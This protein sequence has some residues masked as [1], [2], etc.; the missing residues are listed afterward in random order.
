[1]FFS[2]RSIKVSDGKS[3]LP[4]SYKIYI[5]NL[6]KKIDIVLESHYHK[7]HTCL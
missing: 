3:L 6:Q 5:K 7:G 2:R 1:M 4:E